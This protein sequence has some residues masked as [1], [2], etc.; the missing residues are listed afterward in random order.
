M[1]RLVLLLPLTLAACAVRAD[2]PP[3]AAAVGQPLA[4]E[5]RPTLT[6]DLR[7]RWT[8]T[9]VNGR[10]ES[11]LWLELGG[12]GLATITTRGSGVYVAPPQPPTRA[13][14]GC[15]DWYPSGWT[16][17]GDKLILGRE[18]SRR[19]ERGCDEAS[20]AL[21]DEAF[22]ILTQ[23]VTVEFTPPNRLRLSN[24]NGSLV[25]VREENRSTLL[26]IYGAQGSEL[27]KD[28][29][30]GTFRD[31][32]GFLESREGCIILRN[33]DGETVPI[34]PPGTRIDDDQITLPSGRSL[35]VGKQVN[36]WGRY[37]FQ[38]DGT[39]SAGASACGWRG[40]LVQRGERVYLAANAVDQAQMSDGVLVVQV[41]QLR[42]SEPLGDGMLTTIEAQVVDVL[43]GSFAPGE[44][45]LLRHS[46]GQD[47]S[48]QW[49]VGTHDPIYEPFG[50]AKIGRGDHLLVFVN[51]DVYRQMSEARGGEPIS[52]YFGVGFGV[53][54]VENGAIE[55]AGDFEMPETV[56]ELRAQLQ[57]DR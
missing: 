51:G 41:L 11:G 49:R 45:I 28:P 43:K 16:R 52:G 9:E 17:T 7:G 35:D 27:L 50:R 4:G 29:P 13:H 40:L 14:L 54:G 3:P 15:N 19:T 24:E 56:E 39:F 31:T 38:G 42:P 21:D 36:L 37:V 23:P 6:P 20:E 25:L 47:A 22:A 5:I 53:H 55:R 44:Q 8:I 18:M 12:E 2:I 46:A 30:P 48:G 34:W 1:V 57:K 33:P 10:P 26:P 32:G